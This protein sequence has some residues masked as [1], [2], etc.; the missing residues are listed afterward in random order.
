MEVL[1]SKGKE[2]L[3]GPEKTERPDHS[4]EYG[5]VYGHVNK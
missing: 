5:V 3:N 1:V 4:F 2:C